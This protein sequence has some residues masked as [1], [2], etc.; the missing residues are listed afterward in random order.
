MKNVKDGKSQC[1]LKGAAFPSI[2]YSVIL[3]IYLNRNKLYIL[4]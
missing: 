3:M 4:S 1:F 2:D